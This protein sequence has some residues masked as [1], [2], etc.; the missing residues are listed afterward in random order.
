MN[1][2]RPGIAQKINARPEVAFRLLKANES[3]PRSAFKRQPSGGK[4]SKK[5]LNSLQ[6]SAGLSAVN[7]K[8]TLAMS[9]QLNIAGCPANLDGE[10]C[11]DFRKN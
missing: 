4:I 2:K 1:D 9:I 7:S 3:Y 6:K 5:G 10:F 11:S 8:W